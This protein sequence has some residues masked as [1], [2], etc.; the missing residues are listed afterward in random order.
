MK[1]T[2][3]DLVA[4]TAKICDP[5]SGKGDYFTSEEKEVFM[6][7]I[8]DL[9][10]QKV[11]AVLNKL[12]ATYE[13]KVTPHK[14]RAEVFKGETRRMRSGLRFDYEGV[15][16]ALEDA[17]SVA[18]TAF[19]NEHQWMFRSEDE[20]A[21]SKVDMEA[22]IAGHPILSRIIERAEEAE[23]EQWL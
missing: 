9:D 11:A 20:E 2:L 10:K 21:K 18:I 17:R 14:I 5:Y 4:T 19:W 6:R 3:A 13:G 12:A 1:I 8:S 15:S 22:W 16:Y 23:V 7:A